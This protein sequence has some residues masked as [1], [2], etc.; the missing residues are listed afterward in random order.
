MSLTRWIISRSPRRRKNISGDLFS[1]LMVD[2][3][4]NNNHKE[5]EIAMNKKNCRKSI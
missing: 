4:S 1:I 3:S 5:K 2:E